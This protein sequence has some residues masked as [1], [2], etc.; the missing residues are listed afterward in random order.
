[1]TQRSNYLPKR[2]EVLTQRSNLLPQRAKNT[3]NDL[4]RAKNYV[5]LLKLCQTWISRMIKKTTAYPSKV[6]AIVSN[7]KAN[8][9]ARG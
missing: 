6:N 8:R 3:V 7:A 4:S 2:A 5:N 1:M 9:C